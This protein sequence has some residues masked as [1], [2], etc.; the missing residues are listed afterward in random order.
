MASAGMRAAL[1]GRRVL[2]C[3][4][5]ALT[6]VGCAAPSSTSVTPTPIATVL[7]ATASALPTASP[8]STPSPLPSPTAS[9][10]ATASL[11]PTP[12]R[13]D[14]PQPSESDF[15]LEIMAPDLQVTSD[16]IDLEVALVYRGPLPEITV[17]SSATS[18]AQIAFEQTS[19]DLAM[20]GIGDNTCHLY[21]LVSNEPVP[22]PLVK[23]ATWKAG[24][25]NAAFYA[26]WLADPEL[27]LP[28]GAWDVWA[29]AFLLSDFTC[30]TSSRQP[31]HVFGERILR[32]VPSTPLAMPAEGCSDDFNGPYGQAPAKLTVGDT[33]LRLT[34]MFG[35]SWRDG[36][37][38]GDVDY[39]AYDVDLPSS[40]FRL[41][42]GGTVSISVGNGFQLI[43]ARATRY[44]AADYVIG[45]LG[46]EDT[47]PA[48]GHPA[49]AFLPDGTL[50]V[51]MPRTAGS[52]VIQV[53]VEW[54]T[55]CLIGNGEVNFGVVIY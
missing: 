20:G 18:L 44:A 3:L 37:G 8:S 2:A 9:A 50:E 34:M 32:V 35:W 19:G 24:D 14:P 17:W 4:V 13:T 25:R 23:Q 30:S 22:V 12:T 55:P 5:A 10:S 45:K 11:G 16:A 46:V 39:G 21:T 36:S 27:H 51:T 7:P 31:V 47:G 28:V 41:K 54:L 48:L 52:W 40:P 26:E 43:D 42:A 15:E 53:R 49:T 38:S 1:G 6:V 29:S 33:R